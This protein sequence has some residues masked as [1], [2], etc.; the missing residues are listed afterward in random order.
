VTRRHYEDYET[1]HRGFTDGDLP[2]GP[3]VEEITALQFY[4]R[5][6]VCVCGKAAMDG[7]RCA[8]GA[9]HRTVAMA[10]DDEALR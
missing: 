5:E 8:F 10:A 4:Q 6:G 1:G 2:D 9:S 3:L 7:K